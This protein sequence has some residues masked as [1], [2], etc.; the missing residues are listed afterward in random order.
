MFCQKGKNGGDR[1]RACMRSAPPGKLEMTWAS[2]GTVVIDD[3]TRKRR[4]PTTP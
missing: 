2:V 3:G 1:K 4:K